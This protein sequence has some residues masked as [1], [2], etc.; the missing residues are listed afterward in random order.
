MEL[1]IS[2]LKDH[3]LKNYAEANLTYSRLLELVDKALERR[4]QSSSSSTSSSTSSLSTQQRENDDNQS[5]LRLKF[6]ALKNYGL[7][8][9]EEN[10]NLETAIQLYLKVCQEKKKK[11]KNFFQSLLRIFIFFFF[12]SPLLPFSLS[13]IYSVVKLIAQMPLFGIILVNWDLNKM[14]FI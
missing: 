3:K 2:A 9:E 7:M 8:I 14:I 4:S 1:Y 12:S 11:R 5:I 6:L 13:L 10:S